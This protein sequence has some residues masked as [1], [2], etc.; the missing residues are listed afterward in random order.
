MLFVGIDWAET[1]H[2]VCLLTEDGQVLAAIQIPDTAAGVGRLAGLLTEHTTQPDEVVIGIETD[3]GLVVRALLA[4]GY[5]LYAINPLAASRYRD[6][7]TTSRSKS[8]PGDAKML[9][10]LV[11]TDRHN[12][13]P[14]EPDSV[15][16]DALQLLS[17]THHRLIWDRGRHVNQLRSLLR[18]FYPAALVALGA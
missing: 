15:A 6:R 18:E 5:Q 2:A 8:D 1:H 17:R 10:E 14:L 11:R 3:R 12:H 7:H 9:A 16:A 13:R 4:A